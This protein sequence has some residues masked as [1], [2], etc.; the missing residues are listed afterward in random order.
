MTRGK[1]ATAEALPAADAV[2]RMLMKRRSQKPAAVPK[3][4]QA[5]AGID[6]PDVIRKASHRERPWS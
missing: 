5:G 3:R 2:L 4:E 6:K 1:T